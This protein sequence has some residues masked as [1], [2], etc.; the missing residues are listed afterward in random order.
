MAK[1]TYEFLVE[2][3]EF[4]SEQTSGLISIGRLP[5]CCDLEIQFISGEIT[6][7]ELK[8]RITEMGLWARIEYDDERPNEFVGNAIPPK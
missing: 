8:T 6:A 5:D 3:C 4:L 1:I 2:V 7:E